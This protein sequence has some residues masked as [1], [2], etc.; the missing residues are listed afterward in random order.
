MEADVARAIALERDLEWVFRRRFERYL[1]RVYRHVASRIDTPHEIEPL[2][3]RILVETIDDWMGPG[4]D[5]ARAERVL[6]RARPLLRGA[7][8]K[9]NLVA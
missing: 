4:E 2:V 5:S 1:A 6:T 7:S 3:E 9:R 8:S